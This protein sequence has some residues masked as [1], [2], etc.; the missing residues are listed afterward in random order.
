MLS[1]LD[2]D[3]AFTLP[4]FSASELCFLSEASPTHAPQPLPSPPSSFALVR[5]SSPPLL[6][7][8]LALVTPGLAASPADGPAYT[9]LDPEHRPGVPCDCTPPPPVGA[10]ERYVLRGTP[11]A[12]TGESKLRSQ[13]SGTAQWN[14]AEER[15][16]Q[17]AACDAVP[18][19][20]SLAKALRLRKLASLH[21]SDMLHLARVWRLQSDIWVRKG[22]SDRR[23][24]GATNTLP[25]PPVH[26]ARHA[27]L[28]LPPPGMDVCA[29]PG[30][31]SQLRLMAVHGTLVPQLNALANETAQCFLGQRGATVLMRQVDLD[32]LDLDAMV[33]HAGKLERKA[34]CARASYVRVKAAAAARASAEAAARVMC[35]GADYHTAKEP[36]W[37]ML[38]LLPASVEEYGVLPLLREFVRMLAVFLDTW[39]RRWRT[40]SPMG[41]LTEAQFATLDEL[42]QGVTFAHEWLA[43]ADVLITQAR[44]RNWGEYL[45]VLAAVIAAAEHFA[46]TCEANNARR[47]IWSFEL[48]R[49]ALMNTPAPLPVD[50]PKVFSLEDV[51]HDDAAAAVAAAMAA[52]MATAA[53]QQQAAPERLMEV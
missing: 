23:R 42:R 21:K 8:T 33:S 11:G 6:P 29:S 45:Q 35:G 37:R 36:V 12:S 10:D 16:R 15:M 4:I 13:L 48:L 1:D 20:A 7:A 27:P 44:L 43:R 25:L 50:R 14:S 53:Q 2:A 52:T 17:A 41:E 28:P 34:V 5:A 24:V 46:L 30:M 49:P 3:V 22:S 51:P 31:S 19:L 9:C 26:S 47:K 39:E 32:R 40:D 38:S 18:E